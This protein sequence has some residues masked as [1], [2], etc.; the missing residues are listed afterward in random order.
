ML[1]RIRIKVS[2]ELKQPRRE[3]MAKRKFLTA[4]WTHLAMLNYEIDPALLSPHVPAGPELDVFQGRTMASMVGF[5]YFDTRVLG[6]G[7][8]FHRN[9][10][11]VNLR[12]YVRYRSCE[13]WRRGVVF[14]KEL[15]PRRIVA[16]IARTIYDENFRYVPMQYAIT[17]RQDEP[18]V[19]G[20]VEYQWKSADRWNRLAVET[21]GP[22]RPLVEGSEEQFIAEHYWGYTA[23]RDGTTSEYEV[24]HIPWRVWQVSESEFD[25]DVAAL[26]GSQFVEPL[27]AKPCSAFLAEGS[28]IAVYSGSRLEGLSQ[29]RGAAE[30]WSHAATT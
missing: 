2:E 5:L 13:G 27:S 8:P 22:A 11:E 26:Y 29:S 12:F 3:K 4:R 20:K 30:V 24:E 10:P 23:R 25:C 28:P 17:P 19:P 14:V 1:L 15:V 7:F 6:V 18:E 21:I 9:F 16:W